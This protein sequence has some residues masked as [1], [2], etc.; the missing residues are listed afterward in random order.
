MNRSRGAFINTHKND[1]SS[2]VTHFSH[3]HIGTKNRGLKSD[4]T[5]TYLKDKNDFMNKNNQL[6]NEI[7]PN[8]AKRKDQFIANRLVKLTH[9]EL[10]KFEDISHQNNS[11]L[12]DLW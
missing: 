4:I 12:K 9:Q 8:K 3:S 5:E 11:N 10:K 1:G 2:I 6:V 7:R